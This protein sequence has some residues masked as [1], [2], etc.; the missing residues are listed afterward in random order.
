MDKHAWLQI[1]AIKLLFAMGRGEGGLGAAVAH[2]SHQT[3]FLRACC[4]RVP[5]R[6][7]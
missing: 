6:Y 2:K 5:E 4:L 7:L 3:L 1:N